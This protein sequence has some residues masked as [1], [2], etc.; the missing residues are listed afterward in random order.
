MMERVSMGPDDETLQELDGRI[1]IRMLGSEIDE[2]R[3]EMK[4]NA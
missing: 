3:S 2:V 4:T 1:R